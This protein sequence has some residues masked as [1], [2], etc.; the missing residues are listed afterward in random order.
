MCDETTSRKQALFNYASIH[1]LTFPILATVAEWARMMTI[2]TQGTF[3]CFKYAAQQMIKQ[4]RGGRIIG[5]SSVAGKQG[6]AYISAY[7]A[8]KFA[9]RGLTQS[10]G[11]N[12][13]SSL[14]VKAYYSIGS[15][16]IREAWHHGQCV[17]TWLVCPTYIIFFPIFMPH[18]VPLIPLCVSH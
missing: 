12:F 1:I 7:S 9:I 10:A 18:K 2:N 8:S 14:L 6:G 16:R 3:L 15:L 13:N 17:R 11:K 4:G 5:A